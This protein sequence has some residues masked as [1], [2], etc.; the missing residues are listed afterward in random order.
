LIKS[1]GLLKAVRRGLRAVGV[2]GVVRGYFTV[3]GDSLDGIEMTSNKVLLSRNSSN[4]KLGYN[5]IWLSEQS[6]KS[7]ESLLRDRLV[8]LVFKWQFE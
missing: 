2:Q 7:V 6:S 8:S 1:L 5:V 3:V 4:N